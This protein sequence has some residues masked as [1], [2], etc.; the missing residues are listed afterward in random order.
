MIEPR[1][2]VELLA[3]ISFCGG[4]L[5]CAGAIRSA[6]GP[7]GTLPGST[8]GDVG[9]APA[10]GPVGIVLRGI[11]ETALPYPPIG[12]PIGGDLPNGWGLEVIA[13]GP[14]GGA[15]NLLLEDAGISIDC[16]IVAGAG[17]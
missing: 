13:R 9:I 10:R 17:C 2:D 6:L 7:V 12:P 8:C 1:M 3:L 5:G 15:S 11:G 4:P 16:D 14:E